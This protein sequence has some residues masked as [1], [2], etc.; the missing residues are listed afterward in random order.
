MADAVADSAMHKFNN[1]ST[2]LNAEQRLVAAKRLLKHVRA[3]VERLETGST[4]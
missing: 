1:D 3:L 4:T 2:P